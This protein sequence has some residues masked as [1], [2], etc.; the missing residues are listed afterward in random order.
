MREVMRIDPSDPSLGWLHTLAPAC[1]YVT[2]VVVPAGSEPD[3][4]ATLTLPACRCDLPSESSPP[5]QGAGPEELGRSG[6]VHYSESCQS[7]GRQGGP[8]PRAL[9]GAYLPGFRRAESR[10]DPSTT[11]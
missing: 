8:K 2:S 9:G 1:A 4:F 5:S 3:E 10:R 6:R 7:K 11:T